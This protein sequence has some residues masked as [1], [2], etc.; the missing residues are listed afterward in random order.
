MLYLLYYKYQYLISPSYTCARGE[1]PKSNF[2]ISGLIVM[3]KPCVPGK[4]GKVTHK[5]Q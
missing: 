3:C 1:S 4:L 2:K 5:H